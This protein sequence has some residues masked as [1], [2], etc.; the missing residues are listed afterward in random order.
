[1]EFFCFRFGF[2]KVFCSGLNLFSLKLVGRVWISVGAE[3]FENP[4]LTAFL[5]KGTSTSCSQSNVHG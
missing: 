4:T 5:I 1:M 3:Y 2:S